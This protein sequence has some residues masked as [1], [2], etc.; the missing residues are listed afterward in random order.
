MQVQGIA[1]FTL[2]F[3]IGVLYVWFTRRQRVNAKLEKEMHPQQFVMRL[4]PAHS[5]GLLTMGLFFGASPLVRSISFFAFGT[6]FGSTAEVIFLFVQA[7]IALSMV[8]MGISMA[9]WQVHVEGNVLHQRSLFRRVTTSFHEI[10][11]VEAWQKS[12]P[13]VSH[14]DLYSNTGCLF[15]VNANASGYSLFLARLKERRIPGTEGLL[16]EDIKV[17]QTPEVPI[18]TEKVAETSEGVISAILKPEPLTKRSVLL[19]LQLVLIA[20]T[21]S[22]MA[23]VLSY[24]DEWLISGA[25]T[26]PEVLA[27]YLLW[28]RL[29]FWV[30]VGATLLSVLGNLLIALSLKRTKEF[31]FRHK[32][33][34]VLGVSLV[35]GFSF[36]FIVMEGLPGMIRDARADI[37]AL[38]QG[39]LSE[40][41][42]QIHLSWQ[43]YYRTTS[44]Q[45]IG[46]YR[47]LYVVRVEPIGR[48]YF[49]RSFSPSTLKEMAADERYQPPD[50]TIGIRMFEVW[51]TPNLHIVI[52]VIPIAFQPDTSDASGQ[53]AD[54]ERLPFFGADAPRF[55]GI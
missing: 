27:G 35:V 48:V 9:C 30:F 50:I 18:E 41:T 2:L 3:W 53:K 11:R 13:K 34:A 40:T 21:M 1:W 4:P 8:L 5:W 36:I 44:V 17:E 24:G 26:G 32:T 51:Y 55:F 23:I 12:R 29:L 46:E 28:F 42:Y 43:N 45:D 39:E 37:D 54:E 47:P 52:D 10:R 33:L 19:W 20:V 31:Q 15:S 38:E 22:G 7:F 16:V 25:I 49:P 6:R 14:I